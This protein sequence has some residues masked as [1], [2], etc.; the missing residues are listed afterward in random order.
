MPVLINNELGVPVETNKFTTEHQTFP[1]QLYGLAFEYLWLEG[2]VQLAVAE[3]P[4]SSPSNPVPCEIVRSHAPCGSLVVRFEIVR[5]GDWP[6]V[7]SPQPTDSNLVLESCRTWVTAPTLNVE[8]ADQF[9]AVAGEY[10]YFLK[11]PL[12]GPAV[13]LYAGWNPIDVTPFYFLQPGQYRPLV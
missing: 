6:V 1:Y 9:Y 13:G 12:W 2:T 3:E 5:G 11:R 10:R 8:G 4:S 7:P